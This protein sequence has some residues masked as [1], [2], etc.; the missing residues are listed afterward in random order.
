VSE[1][2]EVT[3]LCDKCRKSG[4]KHPGACC[5][6]VA[7]PPPAHPPEGSEGW[8]DYELGK[9]SPNAAP[10]ECGIRFGYNN[11]SANA[12]H[13]QPNIIARCNLDAGHAGDHDRQ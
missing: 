3:P 4:F 2:A 12:L 8:T 6:A 10:G 11:G 9:R 1:R 5:V 13:G 7:L